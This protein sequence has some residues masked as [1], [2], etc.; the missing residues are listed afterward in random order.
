MSKVE[1][2][3]TASMAV[4]LGRGAVEIGAVVLSVCQLLV[5]VR[6]GMWGGRWKV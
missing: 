2:K 6:R 5:E 3:L 1:A 4:A